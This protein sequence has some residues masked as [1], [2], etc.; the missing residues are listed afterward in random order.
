M[1]AV[2]TKRL[3]DIEKKVNSLHLRPAKFTE[4]DLK[5]YLE[6]C[7][8]F[9][10]RFGPC[11]SFADA[12]SSDIEEMARTWAMNFSKVLSHIIIQRQLKDMK[13]E[14][15]IIDEGLQDIIGPIDE[16]V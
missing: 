4:S 11:V 3:Q 16:A 14:E 7:Q 1:R 9:V 2:H 8:K 10:D 6:G 12:D 5:R 15:F 13:F